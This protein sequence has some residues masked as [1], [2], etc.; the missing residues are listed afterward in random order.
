[1]EEGLKRYDVDL[2]LHITE[3]RRTARRAAAPTSGCADESTVRWSSACRRRAT[4]SRAGRHGRPGRSARRPAPP[5]CRAFASTTGR[6]SVR[7]RAPRRAGAHA[8]RA[9]HR[10]PAADARSCPENDRLARVPRRAGRA[11]AAGRRGLARSRAVHLRGRRAGDAR[12]AG[13]RRRAPTAVFCMSDEMA[14]GALRALRRAGLRAGGDRERGDV[15]IVGFDGHDLADGVRS[16][17]R[18]PSRS[19]RSGRSGRASMLMQ[20]SA[21]WRR[22]ARS[23]GLG[24][25]RLRCRRCRRTLVVRDVHRDATHGRR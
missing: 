3:D 6:R 14:Y 22:T 4:T 2:L 18:V 1:M 13:Q 5:G 11:R 17:D 15:A 24:R 16:V 9:D 12:A 23:G 19:A 7:R 10:T 20:T 8:D 25:R 21:R